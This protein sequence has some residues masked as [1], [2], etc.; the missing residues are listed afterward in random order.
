[1]NGLTGLD[2]AKFALNAYAPTPLHAKKV[3]ILMAE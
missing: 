1:M 3:F 2:V